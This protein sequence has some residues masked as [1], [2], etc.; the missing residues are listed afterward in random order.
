MTT[1]SNRPILFL[2]VDGVVLRRR[3]GQM[4]RR[5]AF[6]IAR[7]SLHFLRWAIK[8]FDV[9][10][11]SSRCQGGNAEEVCHA[12]RYALG[13]RDLPPDWRFLE[14]IPATR[15]G[16]RK[17]DAID[18]STDFY[19]VDDAHGEDSLA[20]LTLH[21]KADRAVQT[22]VDRDPDALLKAMHQLADAMGTPQCSDD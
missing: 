12:F 21:G 10:W 20:I 7:L 19:W 9:R 2:D 17:V 14:T 16:R 13:A 6:E 15:W 4:R 1:V 11:L 5:D 8:N 3:P 18:L 22:S